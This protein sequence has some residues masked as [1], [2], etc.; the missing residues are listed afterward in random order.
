M[1]LVHGAPLF[2]QGIY[3][4]A[5]QQARN[6]AAMKAAT[7]GQFPATAARAAAAN[8]RQ[9]NPALEAT[10]QNIA[11]LR[12]DFDKLEANPTNS[13]ALRNY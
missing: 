8:I 6:A 13:E 9:P 11:G 2:A 4:L 1:R 12:A 5:M 3:R 7:T 10:M